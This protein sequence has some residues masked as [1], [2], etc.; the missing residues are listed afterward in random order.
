[1]LSLFAEMISDEVQQ[2]VSAFFLI[3]CAFGQ[4]EQVALP[5][6]IATQSHGRGT[7]QIFQLLAGHFEI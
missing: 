4:Y 2:R 5:A 3:D 6:D 1:M 7:R